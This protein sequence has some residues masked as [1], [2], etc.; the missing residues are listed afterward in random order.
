[1]EAEIHI[2]EIIPKI[3]QLKSNP[4][5]IISIIFISSNYSIKIDNIEKAINKNDKILINLEEQKN[6]KLQKIK[7]SLLRNN[8][9][10]CNGNLF[11]LKE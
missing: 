10:I 3:K 9:I 1:M 8:Q 2:I 5:D 7:Y 11:Q 4:K 6:K